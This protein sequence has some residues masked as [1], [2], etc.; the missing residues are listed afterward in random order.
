MLAIAAG[1][2]GVRI[3]FYDP[4]D[5]GPVDEFGQRYVGDYEDRE[6]LEAFARECDVITVENEWVDLSTLEEVLPEGVEILPGRR[7]LSWVTNKTVQKS[8]AQA[9][10][11]PVGTFRECASLEELRKTAEDFGFPMMLK[12]PT[13]SYDGYGNAT[14]KRVED[15]EPAYDKL[16]DEG[17]VLVEAWIPFRRELSV[18]VVRRADGEMVTYPIAYTRQENHRCVAVEVPAKVSDEVAKKAESIARATAEAYEIVGLVAVEL[19]ELESGEVLVNEIAPRPHNSGHF[20]IEACAT[21]QFENH[22]RAVLGWPLGDTSL[23]APAAVMVNILGKRQGEASGHHL[24]AALEIPR[25][26]IHIYGKRSVRPNRK[27]GHV[28][29]LADDVDEARARAQEAAERVIL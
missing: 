5:S 21:S 27:M 25:A 13:H 12:R 22:L 11:L 7:T 16:Q 14:V 28:T 1:P 8:H 23:V 2:L 26:S 18:I 10:G 15:L 3:R 4:D 9:Q 29:A 20:S 24:Q 6:K 19:F 17:K